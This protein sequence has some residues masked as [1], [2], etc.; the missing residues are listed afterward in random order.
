MTPQVVVAFV[1]CTALQWLPWDTH[2]QTFDEGASSYQQGDY[3]QAIRIFRMLAAQGD[4]QAQNTLGMMHDNGQGVERD[5]VQALIWYRLAAA[6]GHDGALYNIGV[7]YESGHGVAQNDA[8]ALKWY[9]LA[10]AQGHS[11]AQY[12]LGGMYL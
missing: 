2:A 4:A 5:Y 10:A 1:L 9:L 12:N 7:M 3:P 6:Q 8:E 11:V